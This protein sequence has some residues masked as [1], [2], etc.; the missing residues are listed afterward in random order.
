MARSRRSRHSE[1]HR[2]L[3]LYSPKALIV[4]TKSLDTQP[5]NID[6]GLHVDQPH[7]SLSE[8][9]VS[10]KLSG[11]VDYCLNYL[12]SCA[13]AFQN[14]QHSEQGTFSDDTSQGT[15][16]CTRGVMLGVVAVL[17]TQVVQGMSAP[18]LPLGR[19][20]HGLLA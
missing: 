8:Q 6:V 15:Y 3:P 20:R 7:V 10:S 12:F 5:P 2:K 16:S 4:T 19:I 11:A 9:H 13:N 17:S 1:R 14:N 18:S